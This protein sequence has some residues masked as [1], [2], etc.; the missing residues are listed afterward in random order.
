MSTGSPSR[1]N[2]AGNVHY[3]AA[4]HLEPTSL[5]ELREL[6][7]AHQH[8]KAAGT[9]HSFNGAADSEGVRISLSAMP[10]DLRLDDATGVLSAPGGATYARVSG[11]LHEHGRA[12]SNL[13]SLPHIS[14]AGAVQTGTHGSGVGN[15]ALSGDVL[16]VHLVDA[17]GD[18]VVV[19]T[20]DPD[21]DAVVVGLGAVGVVHR[22]ELRTVPAFDVEQ[23][24]YEGIGWEAIG[25]RLG[26]VLACAYSVSVF[27]RFDDGPA[28][29][30]VKQR[31]DDDDPAPLL[32]D[33]G[34]READV[35]RH[36]IVGVD[37]AHVTP[38]LGG[39]GPS[40]ERLPHFRS[41][42]QP[43]HGAEIQSEYF[44]DAARGAEAVDAVRAIGPRIAHL[45]HAAEVRAIARDPAWLSPS[46]GRDS[47]ALHF[48]WQ[49]DAK[50]VASAV[51]EL[52]AVLLPLGARPHWGKVFGCGADALRRAYPRLDDFA[53]V[54]ARRDPRGRFD[55]AF[56]RGVTGR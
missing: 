8:V 20:D 21:F 39:R 41:E 34:A 40:H 48:T 9:G 46:G 44:V 43:S 47:V 6:V 37:A 17:A 24:V 26:E 25:P 52:E 2:W 27:T 14:L 4:G 35:A 15:R 11:F 42:F 18:D 22:I 10:D 56:L 50:A 32:R 38:Q 19:T 29:V 31:S 49:L 12:L 16:A 1:R 55:N 53:A 45:L 3:R 23:R 51:A 5:A 36:M 30:W 54:V 13:A 33:L 28:Q 7:P